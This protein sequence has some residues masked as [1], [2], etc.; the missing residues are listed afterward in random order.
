M[1]NYVRVG[2]H[3][4]IRFMFFDPRK[5]T[6]IEKVQA[7]VAAQLGEGLKQVALWKPCSGL[8]YPV[9]G[10]VRRSTWAA[11]HAV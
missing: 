2:Q 6:D 9:V 8:N 3:P 10:M 11:G 5:S 1:I 4:D 7:W